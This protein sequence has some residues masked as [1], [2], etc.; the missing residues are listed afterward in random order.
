MQAWTLT[1][2][3]TDQYKVVIESLRKSPLK[4][5]HI[6]KTTFTIHMEISKS[7]QKDADLINT[8]FPSTS[9]AGNSTLG[10]K[11]QANK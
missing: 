6:S 11:Y 3:L 10:Y 7:A 9:R 2:F 1:K 8:L 4:I 5:H